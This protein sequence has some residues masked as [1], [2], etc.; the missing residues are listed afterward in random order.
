PHVGCRSLFP[1]HTHEM[2]ELADKLPNLRNYNVLVHEGPDGIVFLHQIAPGSATKS[3][4]IHVAQLAGIPPEVL[5]R[6]REVLAELEERHLSMP[7][8]PGGSG[9]RR[10]RTAAPSLFANMSDPVLVE[11][12][13]LDLKKLSPEEALERLRRWQRELRSGF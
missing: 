11:L 13:D 2:A 12:R 5:S 7:E 9:P 3:Y 8:R 10:P 1:T 4:G 6:A